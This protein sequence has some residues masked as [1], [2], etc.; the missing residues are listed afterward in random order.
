[1]RWY[2]LPVCL[3]LCLPIHAGS[4]DPV[5]KAEAFFNLGRLYADVGQSDKSVDAFKKIVSDY[6]DSI[7]FK[8]AQEK[9][10][11]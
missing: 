10:S 6:S 2:Y 8:L 3:L 7:Y 5:I 9:V 1:M 4:S 11:R